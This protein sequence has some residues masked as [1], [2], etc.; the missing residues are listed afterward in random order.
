MAPP[1]RQTVLLDVPNDPIEPTFIRFPGLEIECALVRRASYGARIS[2][3]PLIWGVAGVYVLIGAPDN[4]ETHDVRARAGKSGAS[5]AGGDITKRIDAHYTDPMLPWWNRVLMV[6]RIGI[7]F[8]SGEV[9]FLEGELH[10]AL[11]R[12]ERVDRVGAPSYDN[13]ELEDIRRD[14]GDRVLPGILAALESAGVP[15]ASVEDR[16]RLESLQ[17][18]Q[19]GGRS[20]S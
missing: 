14:L 13:S 17:P 5:D 9:G 12:A 11:D 7:S 20:T 15:L 19:R 18:T 6:R 2:I 4:A 1:A 16:H 3:E 10:R 8:R